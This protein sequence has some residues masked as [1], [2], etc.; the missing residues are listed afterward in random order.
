MGKKKTTDRKKIVLIPFISQPQVVKADFPRFPEL[1]LKYIENPKKVDK[2]GVYVPYVDQLIH[3][4]E[5]RDRD[6]EN[7][8][9]NYEKPRE[10]K[11]SR[12]KERSH[13]SHEKEK[14]REYISLKDIDKDQDLTKKLKRSRERSKQRSRER[15]KERSKEREENKEDNLENYMKKDRISVHSKSKSKSDQRKNK[16]PPPMEE[17]EANVNTGKYKNLARI[18]QK[19]VTTE[20][21]KRELLFKIEILKKQYPHLQLPTYTMTNTEE[22]MRNT[23]DTTIKTVMLESTIKKYR[24]WF[25][26]G[27]FISEYFFVKILKMDYMEKS[28]QHHIKYMSDYDVMIIELGEKTYT[29]GSDW[30]VEIRLL[31]LAFFNTLLYWISKKFD[32]PDAMNLFGQF[33][34]NTVDAPQQPAV[35]KMKG[36]SVKLDET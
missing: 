12:E 11:K 32:M 18:T 4:N 20:S 6:R 14:S 13:R 19:E 9:E 25:M 29:E 17:V 26:A 33:V 15:S 31:G 22:Q 27:L 36:P 34:K 21:K 8:E 5:N 23:I 16:R 3:V 35:R 24:R 10:K 2:N 28:T 1:Y 7:K 30:P